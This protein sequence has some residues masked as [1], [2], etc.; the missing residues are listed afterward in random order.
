MTLSYLHLEDCLFDSKTRSLR[1]PPETPLKPLSAVPNR[2]WPQR[3]P[4]SPVTPAAPTEH[5]EQPDRNHKEEQPH[6]KLHLSLL[7]FHKIV[8]SHTLVMRTPYIAG[9]RSR[10]SWP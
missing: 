3:D 2:H 7:S 6:K 5:K 10:S 9:S 4:N 1:E 8:R